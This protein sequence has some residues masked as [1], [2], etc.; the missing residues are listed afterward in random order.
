MRAPL[1]AVVVLLATLLGGMWLGGH[2]ANLPAPL[3]DL[4]R[5]DEMQLVDAAVERVEESYYREVSELSL[6][7]I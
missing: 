5:D 2:S 7:H 4:V 6:I 3:R 1:A